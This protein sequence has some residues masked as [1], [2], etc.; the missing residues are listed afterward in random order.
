MTGAKSGRRLLIETD[1]PDALPDCPDPDGLS[2]S[3]RTVRIETDSPYSLPESPLAGWPL[4]P[5]AGAAQ[6]RA[7]AHR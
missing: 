3:R 4:L 7:S 6:A 5:V 2:G 1:C